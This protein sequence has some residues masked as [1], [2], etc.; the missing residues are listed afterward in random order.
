M[1][2]VFDFERQKPLLRVVSRQQVLLTFVKI[3]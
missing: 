3:L 1:D 2:F